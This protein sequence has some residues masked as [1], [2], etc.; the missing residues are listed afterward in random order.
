MAR[1]ETW[2]R[3]NLQSMVRVQELSGDLFTADNQANRIG[4]IVTDNNGQPVQ[5]TGG[6]IG[7][8]IRPDEATVVVNGSISSNRAWIDLP[9]S[10]YAVK[11]PISIVIKNGNTTIG[12]CHG[13]IKRST[14][15]RIIDP[16]HEVPSL[17]ELL[18]EIANMRTA[19]SAANTAAS[20]ANSA[21]G[22]ANTAATNAN[23]K[24]NVANTAAGA[25]NTAATNANGAAG[26]INNM[27]V[28]A[29]GLTAGSAPTVAVSDVS[30]HKHILFGI[31]KGDKGDPG[32]DFRIKK[33]FASIA[34]MEAYDPS[35]DQSEYKVLEFDYVM[36]DTGSVSDVD[37]GKLY[38]YEPQEQTVWHYIGDLSGAQ[39]IKGETGN[40]IS[41]VQLNQDYTL[42]ITFTDGSSV[43]TASIRGASGNETIDDTA[44][45]GDTDLVYSADKV[46]KLFR[47]EHEDLTSGNAEQVIGK[48][49]STEKGAYLYRRGTHLGNRCREKVVGGTVAWNQLANI[50]GSSRTKTENN[51]TYT[52]NRDGS[53]T[54]STTEQ[55]A[56]SAVMISI[57][58]TVKIQGHKVLYYGMPESSVEGLKFMCG[59][60]G[61]RIGK[62]GIYSVTN[63]SEAFSIIVENGTVILTAVKVVPQF[64]DL[65]AMFGSTVADALYAMREA[66]VQ[67]FRNLFPKDYYAYD[68]G[69]LQS[70]QAGAKK[71][72]CKNLGQYDTSGNGYYNV[73]GQFVSDDY[74]G[75]TLPVYLQAGRTITVSVNG[76]SSIA[77]GSIVAFRDENRQQFIERTASSTNLIISYT[78]KENCWVIA[79]INPENYAGVMNQTKYYAM[80]VQVEYGSVATSYE[81]HNVSHIYPFD[82]SL[83]LRGIPKLDSNNRLYYD[84]DEYESSGKV[85]RRF[86]AI[87]LGNLNWSKGGNNSI[88]FTT[89]DLK[90]TQST[91]T[92]S[93]GYDWNTGICNVLVSNGYKPDTGSNVYLGT[94]DNTIGIDAGGRV[95]IYDSAKTSL[96]ADQF[97]TAMSGV[98]L[99][100]E[101]ATPTTE[102][103]SHFTPI[104]SFDPKGTE[105]FTEWGT[106]DVAI[107]VGHETEYLTDPAKILNN[108]PLIEVEKESASVVTFSDGAEGLPLKELTVKV[109]PVQDL[110][111]YDN[112]W[113]AGGGKNK[114]PLV[115]SDI[116]ANNLGGVW[117]R[118]AFTGNGVTFTILTDESNNVTGVKVTGTA[119]GDATIYLYGGTTSS[120]KDI[121]FSESFIGSTEVTGSS[122]TVRGIV[123][124][125][126]GGYIDG[127]EVTFNAMTVYGFGVRVMNGY[128]I[129]SGGI[130]FK[131]MLR[132]ATDSSGFAPYS[133]ICPI[134][135]WTGANVTRTGNNLLNFQSYT[136]T[137]DW[138]PPSVFPVLSPYLHRK[139]TF[140]GQGQYLFR[141]YGIKNGVE[142]ALDAS[143]YS[144]SMKEAKLVSQYDHIRVNGYSNNA[145]NTFSDC[146]IG[147]SDS[148][149]EIPYEPFGTVYPITFPSSAGTVYGGTLTVNK[150]GSG[151]LVVDHARADMGGLSWYLYDNSYRIFAY[152]MTG[153]KLG[154]RNLLCDRYGVSTYDVVQN[155]TDK[156]IKG[157]P[158]S[159]NVYVRDT[160]YSDAA[161]FKTAVSGSYMLYELE[162]PVTYPLTP[163]EVETLL[164]V[165]NIW[166]DTGDVSVTYPADTKLYIDKKFAELSAAI[167]A[168][169]T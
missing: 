120:S 32:K 76:R 11:G 50:A 65:T 157:A 56:S 94:T 139:V 126:N 129:P 143:A 113:P 26:K 49:A 151:E 128:A 21:A 153:K 25:A 154:N 96:T 61:T 112:P 43:T 104:M 99:V 59:W 160:D 60:A 86:N 83:T 14:T 156:T 82:T 73:S 75:R 10:A 106:R 23:N 28:A 22:A 90:T 33:T 148:S 117:N 52:D 64:F 136:G 12:A 39:G 3:C 74:N 80:K 108:I 13:Y 53:Y 54:V 98:Y 7:Y 84:G 27:T 42:T 115:F 125:T 93:K 105:E 109:E 165:N 6:V 81:P 77:S 18:A 127:S 162:T 167:T 9:A 101:L 78:A 169:G 2:L 40:G 70:V 155:M 66:G 17:S 45:I 62:S 132:L 55:G 19:T 163:V 140:S 124:G 152:G 166:A 48:V 20:S 51:A 58:P 44:G 68:A 30:D 5:L 100:Y 71:A 137:G 91:N 67:W 159:P 133:N 4:V 47:S 144:A 110:H 138:I 145:S 146:F 89:D 121:V 35:Q 97:K 141:L 1:I 134:S 164:G 116:K 72:L 149:D 63:A 41:S 29:S 34:Q 147:F 161:S 111:G 57:T 24:A 15:D 88:C 36:I 135:G 118:N 8:I 107:P 95:Y 79:Q 123:W 130:T 103:A 87:N 122:S 102:Q 38:C 131:P 142:T 150:D 37:T 114:L 158:I 69:S 92:V 168:L 31:P 16:G 85:S 119:D 46:V